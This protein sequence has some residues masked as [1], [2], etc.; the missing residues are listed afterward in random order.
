MR[1]LNSHT[2]GRQ[3]HWRGNKILAGQITAVAVA[4]FLA[5]GLAWP[6]PAKSTAE[7]GALN[8]DAAA[9]MDAATLAA[10]DRGRKVFRDSA[11]CADCHGWDGKAG[12]EGQ[13]APALFQSALTAE[14]ILEAIRC[15]I[16]NSTM[17]RHSDSAWT[18]AAPCY[19]GLV[20]ADI[21]A[22]DFPPA[23]ARFMSQRQLGDV[24]TYVVQVYKLREMTLEECEKFFA[25]GDANCDGFR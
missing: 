1:F 10:V 17:A 13:E 5:I 21:Q 23:A 7:L 3:S 25:A 14:E 2:C 4:I 9:A 8:A 24:A 6:N 22:P 16:P 12:V 20:E 15:G 19:G 18:A 11:G